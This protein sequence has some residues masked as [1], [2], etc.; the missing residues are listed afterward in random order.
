VASESEESLKLMR[1]IDAKYLERPFFGS[2]K[3]ALWLGQQGCNVNRKRVQRLMRLMGIE[4]IYRKPRTTIRSKESRV[5]PYLL[6][7]VEVTHP[8]HVWCAD[9]TYIPM[10]RG[11]MYL[12]AI[13][14]WFSRH[15]IAWR[16]SNS[17]DTSFCIDALEESLRDAKPQIFIAP[18][19]S[20]SFSV[21]WARF[22]LRQISRK[23]GRDQIDTCCV[24]TQLRII[25]LGKLPTLIA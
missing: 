9:I 19:I 13:M 3:M 12:V 21:D 25:E 10:Q 7:N 1:M 15:I 22:Y 6:R 8:N 11:F 20:A 5:Y 23:G 17:L 2:R 16:L 18:F 14:D 4:A 24:L